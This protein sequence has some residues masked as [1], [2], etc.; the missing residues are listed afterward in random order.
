MLSSCFR[1]TLRINTHSRLTINK[2][3][4][5]KLSNALSQQYPQLDAFS[6]YS[7]VKV[8]ESSGEFSK[9]VP[10][11]QRVYDVVSTTTGTNS[12]LS[13]AASM[14]IFEQYRYLGKFSD[15]E[16]A[17]NLHALQGIPKAYALQAI[18]R[19]LRGSATAALEAA[20]EACDIAEAQNSADTDVT[21]FFGSY[22]MKGLSLL[23][24]GDDSDSDSDSDQHLH[25]AE[26]CL[27]QA[28]RWSTCNGPTAEVQAMSNLGA[29]SWLSYT[30]VVESESASASEEEKLTQTLIHQPLIS[31]AG[32]PMKNVTGQY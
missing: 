23:C 12:L 4:T 29:V 2:K 26:D 17:L 9:A 1:M 25:Q 7:Q 20:S 13:V 11:M 18:A 22:T 19:L 14:R 16:K 24:L 30:E 6:E 28:A 32:S 10:L 21:V 5:R 27:Q 15:A 8:F 31:V 3:L